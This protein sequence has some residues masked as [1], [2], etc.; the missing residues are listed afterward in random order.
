MKTS[1]TLA[2]AFALALTSGV[3]MAQSVGNSGNPAR[4]DTTDPN[5]A[6]MMGSQGTR[7]QT[8]G[9]GHM[10]HVPDAA[11]RANT[12]D[13]NS[14]MSGGTG[15]SGQPVNPMADPRQR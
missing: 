10:R 15:A 11:G 7:G 2:M 4:A 5:S 12:S 3:A 6:P 1:T 8:T 9:Q 13:P 14:A